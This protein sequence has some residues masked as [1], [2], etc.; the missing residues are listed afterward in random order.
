MLQHLVEVLPYRLLSV[1]YP[2]GKPLLSGVS[3][4]MMHEDWRLQ[5]VL[6]FNAVRRSNHFQKWRQLQRSYLTTSKSD[7]SYRNRT[8]PLPKVTTVTEIVIDPFQKQ[9]QLQRSYLTTSKSDDSYK[10]RT[11]AYSKSDDSYRDRTWPLPKVTTV[12]EIVID[13]FQKWRQLQRS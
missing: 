5:D 2:F 11:S 13:H 10:D 8:W 6:A 7:D 1:F 9:R 4:K 3:E 12:T